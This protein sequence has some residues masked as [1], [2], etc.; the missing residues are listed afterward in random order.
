M[1]FSFKT[2]INVYEYRSQQCVQFMIRHV[3]VDRGLQERE[4]NN[5]L[6]DQYGDSVIVLNMK[7]LIFL[8]SIMLQYVMALRENANKESS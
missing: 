7:I 8:F 4:N 6:M 1:K 5:H 3:H 2:L